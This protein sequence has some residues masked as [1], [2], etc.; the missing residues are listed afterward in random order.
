MLDFLFS[1]RCQSSGSASLMLTFLL[2]GQNE[3]ESRA[4]KEQLKEWHRLRHD[5]ERARLLLEL[6]RKREKLKREE[7]RPEPARRGGATRASRSEL[8]AAFL[9][10][11]DQT[12]RNP[13]GDAADPLQYFTASAFGPAADERSGQN[14]RPTRRR[15]RG[16]EKQRRK[17]VDFSVPEWVRAD[18]D[19]F[20]LES[21]SSETETVTSSLKRLQNRRSGSVAVNVAQL[22]RLL[23]WCRVSDV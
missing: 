20:I 2:Q 22:P 18:N 9:S 14:L 15:Q 10:V 12:A 1:R 3:E 21:P 6:I 11:A 13:P 16:E 8:H 17:R 5:L 19:R 7:V 23:L 4:L